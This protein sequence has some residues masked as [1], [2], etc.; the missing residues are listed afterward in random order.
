MKIIKET[1]S[2]VKD[3]E[4]SNNNKLQV[5][6]RVV[7]GKGIEHN[8]THNK[9]HEPELNYRKNQDKKETSKK[10]EKKENYK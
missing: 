3:T 10:A 8:S 6:N 7:I 2:I 5:N 1:F 4:N 9:P